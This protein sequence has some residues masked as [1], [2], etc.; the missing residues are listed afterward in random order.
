MWYETLLKQ[1]KQWT[2]EVRRLDLSGFLNIFQNVRI[3]LFCFNENS[4][5]MMYYSFTDQMSVGKPLFDSAKIRE[6]FTYK[7]VL[8]TWQKQRLNF[9]PGCQQT[10]TI[11]F[12]TQVF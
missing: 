5:V 8:L 1:S 7:N 4:S 6:V 2:S 11:F 12:N 3:I 9:G 10:A